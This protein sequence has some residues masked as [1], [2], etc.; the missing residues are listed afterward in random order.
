MAPTLVVMA[1]GMGSRFG[2]TKQLAGVGPNGETIL[3]Y[4]VHDAISAGFGKVV[5]VIRKA[6]ADAFEHGVGARYSHL[7]EVTYVYQELDNLPSWCTPNSDRTKPWGTAHAVWCAR[8]EVSSPFAVINADDFYGQDAFAQ[9]AAYLSAV[10]TEAGKYAMVAFEVDGTLS[11]FGSVSRGV[12]KVDDSGNLIEV[13]EH[14]ALTRSGGGVVSTF[15]DASTALLSFDTLVSMNFWGFT[16]DFLQHAEDFFLQF[17][18]GNH[19]SPK[20]ECYLPSAVTHLM[21]SGAA[22][23]KVLGT[24]GRWFGLTYPGDRDAVVDALASYTNQGVYPSPLVGE[25]RHD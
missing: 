17:Y 7:I 11:P 19:A 20:A 4:S 21:V 23:V 25:A 10:G 6:F 5:F 16:P 8:P 15:T 1:A 22:T 2:G 12:C 3:D 14:T 9:M 18:A 13:T 24:S